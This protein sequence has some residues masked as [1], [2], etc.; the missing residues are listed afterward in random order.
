MAAMG[1]S[2][3]EQI[4]MGE[5]TEWKD[6]GK[7]LKAM[8]QRMGE[9]NWDETIATQ[10]MQT[11]KVLNTPEKDHLPYFMLNPEWSKKDLN[12]ALASWAELKHDAI[13]YAKQPAGAECGGGGPP[14][15]TV[16][17]YVEPNVG[18]WKKAIELLDNT[19]KLL[20]EHDMLTE[21]V[22]S[23]TSRIKEEASF[24]LRISEKE[25]AGEQLTDEE[26]NQIE[27]IG[28]TFE[29]ISLDLVREPNQYLMGWS[30][31]Q[32]ADRK[33][34]LVADVY[35]ANSDNNPNKSILFEAVGDAD[36]IYVVVEIDGYLYLTRGAVLSYREFIQPIDQPRLT[37]EEWQQQLEKNP[38]KGVPEWMKRIIVP[39][40]N[41]PKPN[42]EFFYSSGC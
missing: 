6:F 14:D 7:N 18:F 1:V 9:I 26:Y 12:A 13:L 8:K 11:L 41:E 30:D 20:K 16:K 4:L 3:A 37:D 23:A 25:L 29:N 42:E 21:K 17:G 34:A 27:I 19:E 24:L 35:T 36:E 28:S 31:V 40:K 38:R 5:Q 15:P 32:G 22:S 2:A 10:W 39:L 33:V